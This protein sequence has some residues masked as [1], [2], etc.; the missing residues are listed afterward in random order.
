M[1]LNIK[2]RKNIVMNISDL[3]ENYTMQREKEKKINLP[4]EVIKTNKDNIFMHNNSRQ[5]KTKCSLYIKKYPSRD[6]IDINSTMNLDDPSNKVH[7]STPIISKVISLSKNHKTTNVT[8]SSINPQDDCSNMIYKRKQ[9]KDSSKKIPFAP[10]KQKAS[11]VRLSFKKPDKEVKPKQEISSISFSINGNNTS[12]LTNQTYTIEDD[13]PKIKEKGKGGKLTSQIPEIS[14][15]STNRTDSVNDSFKGVI[16]SKLVENSKNNNS[17]LTNDQLLLL[18]KSNIERVKTI[19]DQNQS[20]YSLNSHNDSKQLISETM[21]KLL[22]EKEKSFIPFNQTLNITKT[23]ITDFS[24]QDSSRYSKE[25][26]SL[27]M[28][29]KRK[30]KHKQKINNNYQLNIHRK[31]ISNLSKEHKD[32]KYSLI[33]DY[34]KISKELN[35]DQYKIKE[36]PSND[37]HRKFNSNNCHKLF[38]SQNIIENEKG[39]DTYITSK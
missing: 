24:Y 32:K 5:Q 36:I 9:S 30:Q 33:Y 38:N 37:L 1:N 22:P 6:N 11:F 14:P 17:N 28:L 19:H 26:I 20:R 2:K 25:D 16:K 21:N 23:C 7:P 29:N 13:R 39:I 8:S 15:L 34:A 31:E 35:K 4:K 27:S 10:Y 12:E 18:V 3:N